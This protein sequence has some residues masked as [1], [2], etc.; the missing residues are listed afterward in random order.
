[1]GMTSRNDILRPS[2]IATDTGTRPLKVDILSLSIAICQ[3]CRS[4]EHV[5][6][7]FSSHLKSMRK[8]TYVNC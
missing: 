7:P 1:M 8:V 4:G 2:N 3:D 5:G 6:Y